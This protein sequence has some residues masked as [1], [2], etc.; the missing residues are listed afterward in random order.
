VTFL[1][2]HINVLSTAALLLAVSL[3]S[4]QAADVSPPPPENQATDVYISV[5]ILDVDQINGVSQSF[6]ANIYFDIRWR[7]P[8]LVHEGRGE[9]SRSLEEIWHPRIQ[10]VNQQRVFKGLPEILEVMP[11]GG[12]TYRQRL[13][14]TFSQPL[15]LQEF[16]FD[17]QDFTLQFISPGFSFDEVN[18]IPNDE[19]Q[20]GVYIADE[21]SLPDWTIDRVEATA[22]PYLITKNDS[23]SPG[24]AVTFSAHRMV[25]YFVFKIIVPLV[26]IVAMSWI[27]FWIDPQQASTQIS[28]SVTS[29]LTL[30]AYRFSID[31][32]LPKV[33]YLTRMD[34]FILGSTVLVFGALL[35][36]VVTS[37][38]ARDGQIERA[39]TMDRISRVVFP[40]V[41]VVVGSVALIF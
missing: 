15:S 13:W 33:S 5:V 8:R 16:P 11:D 28:V 32:M 25:G 17:Q 1:Y 26:L 38:T 4:A 10:I 29:M 37:V 41:F 23:G 39:R 14:G 24:F 20:E 36:V 22:E 18:L 3:L 31:G 27:V 9:V 35:M 7:D 21:L 2:R 30:I 12:V 40:L 19:L 6:D 34:F